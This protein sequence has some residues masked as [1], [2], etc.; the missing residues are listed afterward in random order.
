MTKQ[1]FQDRTFAFR[2]MVVAFARKL[3]RENANMVFARQLIKSATSIGANYRAVCRAKSKA[4]AI[5]KF[6]IVEEEADETLYWLEFIR[7]ANGGP[8]E[9]I[10]SLM[11]EGN[12]I[13]SMVV[14]SIKT[15]RKNST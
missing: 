11:K 1:D 10:D 2:Q 13:L 5:S 3:P 6:G 8:V 14:A 9:E 4:D 7:E 12:E 15:M